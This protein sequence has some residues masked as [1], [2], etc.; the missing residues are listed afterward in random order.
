MRCFDVLIIGSGVAGLSAALT[1]AEKGMEVCVLSKEKRFEES[2]SFYAQGGIVYKGEKDSSSILEKDIMTAG[3]NANYIAAVRMIAS[4]GPDLVKEYLID[5]IGIPFC[6]DDNGELDRTQEAAH[7][8]RRIVHVKDETGKAIETCFIEYI[9]KFRNIHLIGNHSALDIITNCH[10]S[11]DFQE[12]YREPRALGVYALDGTSGEVKAFFANAVIL[13]TGGV[14]NIFLHT[15]NPVGA[16]GDGVAMAY[17]AGASII[18]A[19]Y[20]QFHRSE[21]RRVGKECRSRWSPYH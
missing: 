9:K 14:G 4:E 3:D 12:K 2:N 6:R 7:S 19:E 8:V 18:N 21:E 17:R 10:H 5:K 11:S 13:A 1:A 15:S 16:M 20:V